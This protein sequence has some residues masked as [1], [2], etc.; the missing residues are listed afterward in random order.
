MLAD[1]TALARYADTFVVSTTSNLGRF[2]MLLAGLERIDE[3]RMIAFDL[4]WHPSLFVR[5]CRGLFPSS[6]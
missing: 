1:L 4:W 3:G 5:A 2:A 6:C